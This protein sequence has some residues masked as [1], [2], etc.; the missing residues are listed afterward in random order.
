MNQW[1]FKT[2][3]FMSRPPGFY[4][5]LIALVVCTV[6]VPFG[7]TDLVTYVLSV[8]AII[9]TGVVLIQG[10]RDTAA[11]HAKLDEII[12]ALGETR[13]DVVGLEH[14]D[15]KE[16]QAAVERLEHEAEEL[17]GVAEEMNGSRRP[18][19]SAGSEES[20]PR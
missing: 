16:I 10:Y 7:M 4:L 11:I 2:A 18:A 17:E 15:P 13:N 19:F 9:I 8:A 1:L 12:I 14:A 6:L 20:A 5:V 3:D